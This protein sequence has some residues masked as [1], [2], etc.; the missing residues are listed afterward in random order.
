MEATQKKPAGRPDCGPLIMTAQGKLHGFFYSHTIERQTIGLCREH[1][2]G[3]MPGRPVALNIQKWQQSM[4]KSQLSAIVD[5]E[6]NVQ[7]TMLIRSRQH[8]ST[9]VE[10][11]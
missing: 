2:V 7:Q 11:Q 8:Y 10:Q 6:M 1:V 4:L 3:C 9:C 5:M